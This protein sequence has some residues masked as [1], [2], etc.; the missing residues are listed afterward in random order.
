MSERKLRN[1]SVM[2]DNVTGNIPTRNKQGDNNGEELV[3]D[4]H[5]LSLDV[6]VNNHGPAD[7]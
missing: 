5:R 6:Q 1:R 2:D 7:D 4:E 3:I